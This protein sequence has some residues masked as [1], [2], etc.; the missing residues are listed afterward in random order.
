VGGVDV[1][2][3]SGGRDAEHPHEVQRISGF[4]CLTEDPVLPQ[5]GWLEPE[6]A[7]D[8]VD[9]AGRDRSWRGGVSTCCGD[10]QVRVD[11]VGPA[12]VP[13]VQPDAR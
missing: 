12:P 1:F 7:E 13:L 10:Q 4:P 9:R 5:L 8:A 6:L 11:G 2:H 3:R